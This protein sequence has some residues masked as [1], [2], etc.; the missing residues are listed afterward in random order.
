MTSPALQ[1]GLLLVR[2]NITRRFGKAGIA[3]AGVAL[4]IAA[5]VLL[6]A[7][8]EGVSDTMVRNSVAIHHGDVNV[9]WQGNDVPLDDLRR[10]AG[11][12]RILPRICLTG[13]LARSEAQAS[14]M[15]YAV[16]PDLEAQETAV[17]RRIVEGKNVQ[18]A[19]D[20]LVGSRLAEQLGARLGDTLQFW[21][22]GVAPRPFRVCG[23]FRTGIELLDAKTAYTRRL[24]Q[25]APAAREIAVFIE[26]GYD[27]HAVAQALRERLGPAVRV[28]PWTEAL[29]EL[30]QLIGLNH[31][32]MNIVHLLAL[33][34]LGFGVSNTVFISVSQRTRE[35]GLLKAMGFTPGGVAALVLTEVLLLVLAAGLCG[36]GLGCVAVKVWSLHGLDLARWTSE[37]PHFVISGIVHPRLT[38][39]GLL[40]PGGVALCCGVVAAL[41]PARR[42]GRLS[43][44]EAL[45]GL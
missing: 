40:L 14:L 4:A 18:T 21:Q 38:L 7:I 2:R 39:R 29:T 16:E 24:L 12:R 43:V 27:P 10:L 44:I 30:V 6:E 11:V 17:P 41:L 19:D 15:L 13:V 42:A 36:A 9:T 23:V 32:A 33:L 45:R 22:P 37:N 28:T 34:V 8:M 31:V 5:L 25:A 1:L 20:I 3:F 35:L 26:P